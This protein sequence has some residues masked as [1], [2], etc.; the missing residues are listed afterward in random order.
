MLTQVRILSLALDSNK[1][2]N[3]FKMQI[4]NVPENLDF[5]GCPSH[6]NMNLKTKIILLVL[7]ILVGVFLAFSPNLDKKLE[8]YLVSSETAFIDRV[9][10]GDTVE[11]N[12]T[13]IR[14]LGI[15]TPERGE[16]YYLEAKEFLE[17]LVLN[18]T[19]RL[20]FGKDRKDMYGRTLA[21]LYL[22]NENINQKLIEEGYANFY[23]PSGKD[24]YYNKFFLAWEECN[25]NLCEVSNNKC[26]NCIKLKTF[27][28]ENEV[29]VFENI[30]GFECELT[31]WEIKDE[32]RKKFVLPEFTLEPNKQVTILIGEGKD[33][34][35]TLYWIRKDY[36]WTDSGDT[37]FLRDDGGS[38]VLWK[39][40]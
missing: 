30:C 7:L 8:G 12:G 9:I 17:E 31:N 10:D 5:L 35:D 16:T 38:L 15:N 37:L 4:L 3:H 36:V 2:S 21:Y 23:F 27:D 19:V 14:L 26:S 18:K 28:Y 39:N 40:Y 33:N 6:I 32:G 22:G 25:E 24:I 29:I 34:E 13:S 20:K 1:G 11:S